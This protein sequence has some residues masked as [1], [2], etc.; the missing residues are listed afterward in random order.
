MEAQDAVIDWDD[1]FDR[2]IQR[3][4]EWRMWSPVETLADRVKYHQYS[5]VLYP[6]IMYGYPD[7]NEE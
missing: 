7:S 5:R 1:P 3:E 4:Y 6:P 2:E